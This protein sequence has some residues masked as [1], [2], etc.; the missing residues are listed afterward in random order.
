MKPAIIITLYMLVAGVL[1]TG[2]KTQREYFQSNALVNE[3]SDSI[4]Y[5]ERV[6]VDTIRIPRSEVTIQLPYFI[7]EYDTLVVRDT[8]F[9]KKSGQ[10]TVQAAISNGQLTLSATCDSL[11]KIMLHY[12]RMI[13]RYRT[14]S[15]DK[16]TETTSHTQTTT[17]AFKIPLGANIALAGIG[18]LA[19]V[20]GIKMLT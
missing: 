16:S 12:D 5:V 9:E 13:E 8:V 18:V 14:A 11:E 3:Q 1:L 15:S 7:Y 2:C 17:P 4:R 6:K 10:A 19:I 20:W